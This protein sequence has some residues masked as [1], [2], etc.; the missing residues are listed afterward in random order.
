M[1]LETLKTFDNSVEA[2]ILKTKLE[3]EGIPCYL[4]DEHTVSM[5]PLYN[6]TLGGIKLKINSYDAVDALEVL[7][8]IESN[9]VTDDDDKTIVFPK[10]GSDDYYS[11]FKSMKGVGGVLMATI[12]IL[13][14]VFPIFLKNVHKCKTCGTEF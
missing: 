7:Q 9:P 8:S 4:F 2:H 12:S 13:L 11:G 3:S 14:S 10:C 6:V 1:A 5:N